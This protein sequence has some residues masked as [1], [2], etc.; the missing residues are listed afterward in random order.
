MILQYSQDLQDE[1]IKTHSEI[2]QLNNKNDF[3][4][5]EEK[6]EIINIDLN[7]QNIKRIKLKNKEVFDFHIKNADEYVYEKIVID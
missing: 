3:Y 7:N 1:I 4:T 2:T 5:P 6:F